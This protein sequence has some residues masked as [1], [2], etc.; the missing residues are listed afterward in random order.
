MSKC[1]CLAAG[2]QGTQPSDCNCPNFCTVRENNQCPNYLPNCVCGYPQPRKVAS[3]GWEDIHKDCGTDSAGVCSWFRG[4]D[5]QRSPVEE[6]QKWKVGDV[7]HQC[8]LNSEVLPDEDNRTICAKVRKR[9]GLDSS[10]LPWG[11]WSPNTQDYTAQEYHRQGNEFHNN[12]YS[13]DRILS[14]SNPDQPKPFPAFNTCVDPSDPT[15]TIKC[16]PTNVNPSATQMRELDSYYRIAP[17]GWTDRGDQCSIFYN[18][19]GPTGACGFE[20]HG[21]CKPN[22]EI[23]NTCKSKGSPGI[24][25]YYQIAPQVRQNVQDYGNVYNKD[26]V[27]LV[28]APTGCTENVKNCCPPWVGEPTDLGTNWC[29][30]GR[31]DNPDV[32][33][34]ADFYNNFYT[35]A[36]VLRGLPNS[37][38]DYRYTSWPVS[39]KPVNK[40]QP[41]TKDS[42]YY[43]LYIP[44]PDFC[45]RE[46][47]PR[48][49]AT[50]PD[51]DP[52]IMYTGGCYGMYGQ[53]T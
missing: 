46:I 8:V 19:C 44:S 30:L 28:C 42:K 23:V 5:Y 50:C 47:D 26:E 41:W 24:C 2:V 10:W 3:G 16:P 33:I 35:N 9:T 7:W 22:E 1:D 38:P 27:T 18:Q 12:F 32:G 29:P 40:G 11:R 49:C 43:G 37:N 20:A 53:K 51:I 14:K 52:N 45:S 6:T 31:L 48:K 25:A 39:C 34:K 17:A 21:A 15:K 13:W 4:E 36:E